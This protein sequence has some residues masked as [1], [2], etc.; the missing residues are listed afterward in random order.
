M[1][2][3]KNCYEKFKTRSEN[4]TNWK[5]KM[6]NNTIQKRKG[7]KYYNGNSRKTYKCY[8]GI[9]NKPN[10]PYKPPEPIEKETG[11][12]Y[13]KNTAQREP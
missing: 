4:T 13:N 5:G 7:N 6:H 10:G 9:I 2:K 1:R 11:T 12:F 8:Q 3:E